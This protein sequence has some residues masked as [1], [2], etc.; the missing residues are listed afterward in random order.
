MESQVIIRDYQEVPAGDLMQ[1][2]NNVR[3][4][5]DD[6]VR[7]AVESGQ[8]YSALAV[9]ASGTW[10]VQIGAGMYYAAGVMYPQTSVLTQSLTDYQPVANKVKIAVVAWGTEGETDTAYRDFEINTETHE[11]EARLV[12]MSNARRCSIAFIKGVESADPQ[13]PVIPLSRLLIASITLGTTGIEEITMSSAGSLASL[14]ALATRIGAIENWKALAEPKISTIGS[15][16]ASLANAVRA[17]T[18]IGAMLRIAADVALLKDAAGLPDDYADY[19]ADRYLDTSESA[20][21]DPEFLALV[22]EGIRFSDEA[23]NSAAIQ[24]FNPINSQVSQSGGILMPAYSSV[25]RTI[26]DAYSGETSIAQYS[27]TSHTMVQKSMSRS[28]IR[29][30]QSKS[31]CT[32]SSWWKSGTYNAATGVFTKNG[33]TWVVDAADLAKALVNHK[34]IRVTQFF[35]DTWDETY[36]DMVDETITIAGAQIAQSFLNTQAGWLTA[37]DLYF[38]KRGTSG[39]VHLAICELTD[40]A[41]PNLARTIFQTTIPYLSINTLAWTTVPITPTFLGAGKRYAVVLTTNGN[42]YVGMASGAGAYV[43]GTFFYSTDGAYF[44]GDLSRDMMF[45]LRFAQFSAARIAVDLQPLS[46]SG[47]ITDIDILAGMVVPDATSLT[48]QVQVGGAWVPLSEVTKNA[49]VGLPPLL[50]FQAV[51]QGTGD[52]HAGLKLNDSQVKVSRPRT[53]FKH[54]SKP[55]LLPAPSSTIRIKQ[56]LANWNPAHHTF[57][58]KLVIAGVTFMP[59]VVEDVDLGDRHIERTSLFSL[60]SP[61]TSFAIQSNGTTTTPLDVFLVEECTDVEL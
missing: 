56:K 51:F 25:I 11:A 12:T 42:H 55:R 31:V 32:N 1:V 59:S 2:Q 36:W 41:T 18:D 48:F 5:F 15:D 45:G 23:A 40:S 22:E 43:G 21:T 30:G 35:S 7:Y 9:V 29:Y 24:I 14:R 13:L 50:P 17:T 26:V 16:V 33:E 61:T 47:G 60:A 37:V 49:L 8:A 20:T 52:I 58:C 57:Q 34:Y 39:N 44:A 53:V 54:I 6:L 19:G 3:G 28:R 27:Q 46:L 10:E 4:T 38:T